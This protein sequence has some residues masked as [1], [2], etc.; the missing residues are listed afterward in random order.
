[1]TDIMLP[2]LTREAERVNSLRERRRDIRKRFMILGFEINDDE[3]QDEDAH[4][5]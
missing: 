2:R 3:R 1:M 5:V 4:D